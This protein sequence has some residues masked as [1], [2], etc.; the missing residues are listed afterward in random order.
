MGLPAEFAVTPGPTLLTLVVSVVIAAVAAFAALRR[1]LR[2]D[3]LEAV[4]YE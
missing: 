1:T 4:A 3:V 2:V